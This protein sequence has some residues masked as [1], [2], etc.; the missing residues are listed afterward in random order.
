MGKQVSDGDLRERAQGEFGKVADQG[1][2]EGEPRFIEKC[3]QRTDGD[4]F[5][6]RAEQV[7]GMDV[8]GHPLVCDQTR[9]GLLD[10]KGPCENLFFGNRICKNLAGLFAG[11]Q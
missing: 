1:I 6:D 8:L 3:H 4:G 5:G 10:K 9:S 7:R 11:T 2:V